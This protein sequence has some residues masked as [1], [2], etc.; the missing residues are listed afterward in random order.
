MSSFVIIAP[1][2]L[3]T[4]SADLRGI[5]S[6]VRAANAAASIATTQI[7]AAGADEVSA[8]LAGVFGGFAAEYQALSAQIA[9][10]HD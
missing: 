9:V 4:A 3:S 10:F 7:A 1:E 5:G 8:A 6:A 2:I